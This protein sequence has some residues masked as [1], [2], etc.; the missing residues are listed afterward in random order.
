MPPCYSA[1]SVGEIDLEQ[2]KI[3]SFNA[4]LAGLETDR[5]DEMKRLRTMRREFSGNA[6][7]LQAE[8]NIIQSLDRAIAM[9]KMDIKEATVKIGQLQTS[10]PCS[11]SNGE[12]DPPRLRTS[13]AWIRSRKENPA[14]M[15]AA[16][17]L[18]TTCV[19]LSRGL[20]LFA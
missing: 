1:S 20:L 10:R 18:H 16:G 3:R 9:L 14:T 19:G 13:F 6:P 4:R 8:E 11:P 2:Q 5:T 12:I 15:G 17:G 7:S